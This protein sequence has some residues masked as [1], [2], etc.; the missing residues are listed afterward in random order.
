M[1]SS[2][3]EALFVL[4]TALSA[5]LVGTSLYVL[6]SYFLSRGH[7][8]PRA[9]RQTAR[10]MLRELF[11]ATGTSPLVPL[12]YFLGRRLA[13]G[14]REPIVVVH[15]Y[16]QNRACFVWLAHRLGRDGLGPV[17]GINYPWYRSVRENGERLRVFI[18]GVCKETG[19]DRVSLIGHSMGGLVAIEYLL[20][21]GGLS[22]VS[23]CVT[24]ASPHAGVL[25]RG[26]LLGAARRE[27][28]QGSDLIVSLALPLSTPVLSIASSHDNLAYPAKASS[29]ALRGGSDE[30][31]D[32]PGHL[33]IL[34]DARVA[35]L[36]ATFLAKPVVSAS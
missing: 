13:T 16:M 36:I 27:L 5:L 17:Y 10:E 19:K 25:Y 6:G 33:A 23:K 35:H 11:W 7:A 14:T 4:A 2:I 18:E 21:H 8:E 22:S 3:R 31:V 29:L 15:G 28:R 24:I 32:G 26:P 34:F 30:L 9:F 12:Y 20:N 1:S